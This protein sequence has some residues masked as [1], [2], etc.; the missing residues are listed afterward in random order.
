[1]GQKKRKHLGDIQVSLSC[2][3][4]NCTVPLSWVMLIHS[5]QTPEPADTW[6]HQARLKF[7][8]RDSVSPDLILKMKSLTIC[9]LLTSQWIY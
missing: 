1:V 2:V 6:P 8:G 4:L 9:V 5:N 3:R 7:W